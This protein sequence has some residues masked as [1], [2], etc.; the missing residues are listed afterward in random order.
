ML[1]ERDVERGARL[2]VERA[3]ANVV[4][5]ADDLHGRV[6]LTT[7]VVDGHSDGVFAREK[8]PREGA[9]DEHDVWLRGVLGGCEVTA[10]E[11]PR[12]QGLEIIRGDD[13]IG[14]F[15]V[16]AVIGATHDDKTGSEISVADG[17]L[18]RNGGRR[19]AGQRVNAVEYLT[20]E[21]E[22]LRISWV[23]FPRNGK[24]KCCQ[25]VRLQAGINL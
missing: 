3:F 24:R 21:S 2:G 7:V 5:D 6:R 14:H 23:A 12:L 9:I 20:L 11:Q 22:N 17:Q 16:L 19:H 4:D 13:A 10:F 15:V 1:V 18:V 8:L 25:I